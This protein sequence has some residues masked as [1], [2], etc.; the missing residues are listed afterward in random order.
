MYITGFL[1]PT[2]NLPLTKPATSFNLEEAPPSFEPAEDP[3][4]FYEGLRRNLVSDS[5]LYGNNR[6]PY[7]YSVQQPT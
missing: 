4:L 2:E 6:M 1:D 3:S 5:G 7:A